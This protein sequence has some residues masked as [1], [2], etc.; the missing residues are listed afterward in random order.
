MRHDPTRSQPAPERLCGSLGPI[1][2]SN[3][4]LRRVLA[5]ATAA[6]VPLSA[7]RGGVVQCDTVVLRD[8]GECTALSGSKGPVMGRRSFWWRFRVLIIIRA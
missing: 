6:G 3:D 1:G 5:A 4:R 8:G 2:R 7:V